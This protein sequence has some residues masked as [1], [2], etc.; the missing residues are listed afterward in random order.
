MHVLAP[1]QL[2]PFSV[3][4]YGASS[5]RIGST[6]SSRQRAA[7]SP[8]G[9]DIYFASYPHVLVLST[10]D[11]NVHRRWS[12]KNSIHH[13]LAFACDGALIVRADRELWWSTS[14]PRSFTA[15]PVQTSHSTLLAPSPTDPRR[16]A[17]VSTYGPAAAMIVD[18]SEGAVTAVLPIA[19]G[20][21]N[22]D[23]PAIAIAFSTDGAEVFIAH[24]RQILRF[25]ARTGESRGVLLDTRQST[26]GIEW[27]QSFIVL[28]RE[29]GLVLA[30]TGELVVIDLASGAPLARAAYGERCS[31]LSAASAAGRVVVARSGVATVVDTRD[32]RAIAVVRADFELKE[33]AEI[34]VGPGDERAWILDDRGAIHRLS[35]DDGA[36]DR[37]EPACFPWA[38][39]WRGDHLV[40]ARLLS[41]TEEIDLRTGESRF[42]AMG[43]FCGAPLLSPSADRVFAQ[44][45]ASLGCWRALADGSTTTP[46]AVAGLPFVAGEAL[47]W[48]DGKQQRLVTDGRTIAIAPIKDGRVLA[49]SPSGRRAF[50]ATKSEALIVDLAEGAVI[51]RYKLLSVQFAKFV[52][53]D[54][55]V[56]VGSKGTHWLAALTGAVLSRAPKLFAERGAVSSDGAIVAIASGVDHVA[57][58]TRDRPDDVVAFRGASHPRCLAFS[59][60]D[61]RLAVVGSESVVRVF[62][63]DAA[64]ATRAA[65]KAKK[66]KRAASR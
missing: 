9:A 8:D 52:T 15:V 39:A 47:W 26:A 17:L 58:V 16:C 27:M 48:L 49:T 1:E 30:S 35:L 51:A 14:E 59:P 53:E 32:L 11:G 31:H 18:G 20:D 42:V 19:A 38:L 60:D 2:P 57:M 65:P 6:Y 64:L 54:E 56:T 43:E 24:L 45:A 55:L 28:D 29:R 13:Q 5:F 34:L 33:G 12:A 46:I 21:V 37:R 7:L 22:K 25:D 62:D 4:A 23:G 3:A 50:V 10:A 41:P 61:K 44:S 40:V 66:A 63:V 36:L